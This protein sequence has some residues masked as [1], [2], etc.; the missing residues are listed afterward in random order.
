VLDRVPN[1]YDGGSYVVRFSAP[2]FTVLCAILKSNGLASSYSQF[3]WKFSIKT[4]QPKTL[5]I[6]EP[7]TQAMMAP[8]KREGNGLRLDDERPGL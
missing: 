8:D 6:V 7:N 1:P 4:T 5:K 2:E 3:K